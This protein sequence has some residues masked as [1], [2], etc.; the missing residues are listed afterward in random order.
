MKLVHNNIFI[1]MLMLVALIGQAMA[2]T[3]VSYS[4][5]PC[6]HA[7]MNEGMPMSHASMMLNDG[8]QANN[9][10][11]MMDC[12][13]E[14]CQCPMNGCVS[15]SLLINSHFNSEIIAEQKILQSS[16]SHQSQVNASLYRPPIS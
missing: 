7:S 9:Q 1:V 15:L 5:A 16:S 11:T 2:G 14:Q 6:V 10:V 12:C 3:V 4:A 8:E 13:Q